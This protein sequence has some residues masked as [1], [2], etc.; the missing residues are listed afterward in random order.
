MADRLRTA[1]TPVLLIGLSAIVALLAST[2]SSSIQQIAIQATVYGVMA[3][4]LYIFVGNS[5][6]L[7]FG[8]LGFAMIGGYT[9]SLMVLPSVVKAHGL[10]NPPGF[11]VGANTSPFFAVLIAGV[12]AAVVAAIV[13]LPLMRVAGLPAGLASFA[14]LLTV[15]VVASNLHGVTAG[16]QGLFS[17]P[18]ATTKWSALG[19]L[20]AAI[21]VAALYQRSRFGLMLR[22]TRE[23]E[24]A[25]QGIGVGIAL[26]RGIAFVISGF[27][28]GVG[29]ALLAMA[30]GSMSPNLI[31]LEMTLII[32]SMVVIGG[33]GSLSGAVIGAIVVSVLREVLDRAQD[34]S[35]LGLFHIAPRPGLSDTA[36]AIVLIALL[37]LRPSGLTAGRELVLPRS[38]RWPRRRSAPIGADAA[39]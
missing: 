16:T 30:L 8:H 35:V 26:Q 15:H 9:G 28:M 39:P 13:A 32:L 5:G 19:W 7:S 20:A 1:S 24:I 14:L 17:I 22:T 38:L 10:A 25:A 33:L 36:L 4:G 6:V 21:V 31:Y 29:G 2:G 37:I 23:E 27:F 34:G 18:V 11:I 12:V 3:V